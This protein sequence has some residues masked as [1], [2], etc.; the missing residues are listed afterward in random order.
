MASFRFILIFC[1]TISFHFGLSFP[2]TRYQKRSVFLRNIQAFYQRRGRVKVPI[3][4]LLGLHFLSFLASCRFISFHF[5]I[6]WLHFFSFPLILVFGGLKTHPE[7]FLCLF[8]LHF[9]SC[10]VFGHGFPLIFIFWGHISFHFCL[11]GLHFLL[12]KPAVA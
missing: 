2:F 8:E 9:L 4:G 3:F 1:G 12:F 7:A 5:G 10:W 6:L 11:F